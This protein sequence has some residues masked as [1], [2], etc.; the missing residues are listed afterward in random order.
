MVGGAVTAT[1]HTA[2]SVTVAQR[3]RTGYR[4]CRVRE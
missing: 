3:W 4:D 2:G 1:R